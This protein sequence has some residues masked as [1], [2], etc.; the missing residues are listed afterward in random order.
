MDWSR[1]MRK[2]FVASSTLKKKSNRM[3]LKGCAFLVEHSESDLMGMH[4][5]KINFGSVCIKCSK[6]EQNV[7]LFST[8]RH[9]YWRVVKLVRKQTRIASDRA[10]LQLFYASFVHFARSHLNITLKFLLFSFFVL[11]FV[12]RKALSCISLDT[13]VIFEFNRHNVL[14]E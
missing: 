3:R 12:G 9:G 1:Q 14:N 2:H 8:Y 10:E 6:L 13:E 5:L 7:G 4:E 11:S